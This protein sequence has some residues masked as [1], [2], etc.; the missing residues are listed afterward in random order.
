MSDPRTSN[1]FATQ[2]ASVDAATNPASATPADPT[3][4]TAAVRPDPRL[5]QAFLTQSFLWMF[6]GLLLSAGVA[7]QVGQVDQKIRFPLRRLGDGRPEISPAAPLE[8]KA[9]QQFRATPTRKVQDLMNIGVAN[10]QAKQRF[11]LHKHGG[12]LGGET[13]QK[14]VVNR[15]GSVRCERDAP[16]SSGSRGGLERQ[17]GAFAFPEVAFQREP[18]AARP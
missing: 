14:A 5:A 4:A 1:P 13:F 15:A 6:V 12:D 16:S 11:G 8:L 9:A 7:F 2:R 10:D 17:I 18:A 3:A